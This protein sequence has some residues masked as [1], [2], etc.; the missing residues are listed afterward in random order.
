[1]VYYCSTL[2]YSVH[3]TVYY[4]TLGSFLRSGSR[5]GSSRRSRQSGIII[6]NIRHDKN[7]RKE[8]AL[9]QVTLVW[10]SPLISMDTTQHVQR[11]SQETLSV[12]RLLWGNYTLET[13]KLIYFWYL[14]F[15]I[16]CWVLLLQFAMGLSNLPTLTQG[17]NKFPIKC[18]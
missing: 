17:E 9:L 3:N 13:N 12:T 5:S 18:C 16:T 4:S 10:L 2:K 11:T 6:K 7:I 14:L 8:K 15:Y 1:M